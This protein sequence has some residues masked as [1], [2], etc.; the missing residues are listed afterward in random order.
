[1]RSRDERFETQAKYKDKPDSLSHKMA[2]GQAKEVKRF[3]PRD[4]EFN[5]DNTATC[6]AGK[7]MSSSGTIYISARGLHYQTYTAR[8]IDCTACPLSKQ[9]LKGPLKSN[10]GRGRQVTRFEPKAKD[11]N[12]PS[13]R[14]RQAIDSP[15]GRQLYSQRIIGTV[16]PVFAN[17]RH[18]K[19]LT[20]LNHR[21]RSKVNT[22]WNLYCMVHNIEQLAKNGYAQ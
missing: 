4:F 19:R 8:E 20:R 9:C 11:S 14:M 12:H 7:L 10:D 16:E 13:E 17:I 18:N 2:I 21:G 5:D 22:Q 1:M 6:P 3:S 15:K